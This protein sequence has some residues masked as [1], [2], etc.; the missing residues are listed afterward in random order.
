MKRL[1]LLFSI[2]V[3]WLS[4]PMLA[5]AQVPQGIMYQGI[6]LDVA[7]VSKQFVNLNVGIRILDP[8][9]VLSIE[10]A[11]PKEEVWDIRLFDLQGKLMFQSDKVDHG[12]QLSL[13]VKKYPS[14][15]Y[16]VSF[17]T[18]TH[19]QTRLLEVLH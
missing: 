4:L 18:P 10:V 15:I 19:R 13:D 5:Q 8:S 14:G 12:G 17:S 1:A 11:L 6:A 3:C 2:A 9:D 7:G 16:L